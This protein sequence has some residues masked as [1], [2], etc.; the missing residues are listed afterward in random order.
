MRR[1]VLIVL[2]VALGGVAS[3]AQVVVFDV[4]VTLRNTVTAILKDLQA[5][6]EQQQ[7][8]QLRRMAQRLSMFTDLA[9]FRV[10]DAPRW[11]I[12]DFENG[13]VFQFSRGYHAALNYGDG[14]G[15]GFDG[16][17]QQLANPA[18]EVARL[19]AEARRLFAAGLATTDIAAA[20][21]IAGTH[22][23]GRLRFN[24]R[25]ELQAIERL[26]AHVTNGS[27][28]QS[29]TAVLDKIS[30][31]VLVGARQRQARSQLLT[32]I[33]E[34]LLV[35]GKRARDAEA[36]AINMQLATWRDRSWIDAAFVRGTGDALRE[37]RQP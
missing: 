26:E 23:S 6:L 32:G 5:S 15:Q 34:Q 21:A 35:D 20:T 22:D 37:W 16:V 29:T 18:S 1:V 11:R 31:A 17:S 2:F 9:K 8:S 30:G 7:H 28:E 24:G 12:H 36:L 14:G 33:V 27:Q 10:A 3:D 4:A 25:R 13:D 19:P